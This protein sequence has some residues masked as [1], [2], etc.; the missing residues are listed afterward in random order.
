[1]FSAYVLNEECRLRRGVWEFMNGTH[2]DLGNQFW[3]PDVIQWLKFWL[4]DGDSQINIYD[5]LN[6][7]PAD[8]WRLRVY[9]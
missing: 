3:V 1:M 8:E 6:E 9:L 7:A 2:V 4:E 5:H